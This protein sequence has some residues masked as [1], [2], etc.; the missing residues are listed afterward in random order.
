MFY[1]AFS[2]EVR[3]ENGSIMLALSIYGVKPARGAAL[4]WKR[5]KFRSFNENAKLELA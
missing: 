1:V 3:L 4:S 5:D 2:V